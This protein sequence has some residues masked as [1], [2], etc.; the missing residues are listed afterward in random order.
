MKHFKRAAKYL[1]PGSLLVAAGMAH[2]DVPA[3][4]STS[5]SSG[6]TDAATVGGLVLGVIVAIAAFKWIR[7]AI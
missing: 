7:K 5:I 1:V 4:V 6:Q 3:S 2:A